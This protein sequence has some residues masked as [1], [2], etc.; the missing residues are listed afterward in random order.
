MS[1][2]VAPHPFPHLRERGVAEAIR[3]DWVTLEWAK[4]TE[5][6]QF[7]Y[8]GDRYLRTCIHNKTKIVV[9]NKSTSM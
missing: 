6:K 8:F 9:K 4:D 5:I 1:A 2:F 3:A 7:G